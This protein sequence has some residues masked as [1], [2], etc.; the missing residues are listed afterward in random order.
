MQYRTLGRTGLRVS[1]VGFGAWAIGGPATLGETQIGWGTV[2][3]ATSVKA[4]E[5]A[6]D[7]G[8]NFFDTADVYGAGHSEEL[9]GRTFGRRRDRIIISSKVG[10]RV[11]PDN[12]WVKDFSCGWI[13]QTIEGSLKRLRTDYIDVYHLHS[14]GAD[15]VYTQEIV[16]TLEG[17]KKEGKIRWYGI[18]LDPPGRGIRPS[19]QGL[20]ILESRKCDFFQVLYNILVREPEEQLLPA[21]AK[22]NVGVIARVPLA[23]GF[24]T[25]KFTRET[26]F[27]EDDHRQWKYPPEK[28]RETVEKVDRLH[29]LVEGKQKTLAQAALQ[30]C[31]S[32]PA[33][34]TV[35]P[36]AKTAEQARDNAAASDGVLLTEEELIRIRQLIPSE[37]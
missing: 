8:I 16:D 14:P 15:F 22:A 27:P 6:F 12:T 28:I 29:F 10:N 17:L 13:R 24:L 21:C 19:D 32:H 5:T 3:N 35:I 7:L 25:G 1:E 23:S 18:S 20:Q 30:F 31:L 34:S 9:I 36:G 2:D 4:L 37:Q 26:E 33:V 11:T